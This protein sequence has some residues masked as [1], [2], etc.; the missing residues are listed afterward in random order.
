[1]HHIR[2][3]DTART[4]LLTV[5][6]AALVTLG[7]PAIKGAFSIPPALA[8]GQMLPKPFVSRAVDATLMELTPAVRSTFG[9]SPSVRGVFVLSTDPTGIAAQNGILPGDVITDSRG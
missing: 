1:M 8:Q 3:R 6:A 5:S 9:I 4:F 2:P 7:Q